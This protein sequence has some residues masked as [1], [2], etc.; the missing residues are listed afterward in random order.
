MR[1]NPATDVADK[2]GKHHQHRHHQHH[3]DKAR[4]N[5]IAHRISRH[6]T[7][8]INLLRNLHCAKLGRNRRTYTPGNHNS[9]QHRHQLT[10]HRNR[11]NAA[12]RGGRAQAYK[13]LRR[14]HRKYHAGAKNCHQHNR[15]GICAQQRHLADNLRETCILQAAQ[16]CQKQQRQPAARSAELYYSFAHSFTD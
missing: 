11:H 15:Q 9:C 2:I 4:H 10:R 1:H 7:Q 13:L 12:D 5:K 3:C 14:L 16:R 8:R 6:N